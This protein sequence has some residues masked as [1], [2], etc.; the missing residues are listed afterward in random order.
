V[1][2]HISG[3]SG[4]L[5]SA[6]LPLLHA[7][8][9]HTAFIPRA[10][11][12]DAEAIARQLAPGDTLIHL[13][14]TPRPAPW[15]GAAFRA[16]DLPS[17]QASARAARQ[18]RA[19]HFVYV[20]VAHPAPA[21]HAYIAV[22]REAE[23]FL[24]HLNLPRTILRP[25]YVLGPGHRWPHLLQPFYAMAELLPGTRDTARRLGL[26]TLRQMAAALAHAVDH[27]AACRVIEVPEIRR[28]GEHQAQP[29]SP[30]DA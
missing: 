24:A 15:K 27:P 1:T 16:V 30:D 28:L 2:V 4:Y 19:G 22:R 13:T 3:G 21:M 20:S 6:L 14:G 29:A 26:V 18:Q 5:G 7:R 23:A 10:H 11:V 17:L 8:G 12:F 9:H 25:W